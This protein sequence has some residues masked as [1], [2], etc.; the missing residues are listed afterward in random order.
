MTGR[1]GSCFQGTYILV[2]K[3][4]HKQFKIKKY[5]FAVEMGLGKTMKYSAKEEEMACPLKEM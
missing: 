3:I 2:E 5:I 4:N 1:Q